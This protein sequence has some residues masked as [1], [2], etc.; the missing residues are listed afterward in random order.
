MEDL[1][2]VIW[3]NSPAIINDNFDTIELAINALEESEIVQAGAVANIT[4]ANLPIVPAL[5]DTAAVKTYLDS[6]YTP[7]EARLD[8]VDTKLNAILAALRSSGV[9]S[10]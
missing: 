10:S 5:A 1:K 7:L 6:L 2:K 9:I 8:A 4:N 3:Y